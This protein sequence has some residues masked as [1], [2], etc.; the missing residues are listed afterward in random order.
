MSAADNPDA[1]RQEKALWRHFSE[2]VRHF[3][4]IGEG[5]HILLGLS[6]P[7]GGDGPAA[8]APG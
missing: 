3:R 7:G 4:L 2:G 5:D 6:G 1:R 8:R